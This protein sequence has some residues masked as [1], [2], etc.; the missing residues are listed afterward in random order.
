MT[1]RFGQD[2][3]DPHDPALLEQHAKSKRAALETLR[4]LGTAE[5]IRELTRR[6]R[7][8]DQG[9]L[10]YICMLGVAYSP[11]PDVART[12]VREAL[13]DPNHPITQNFL[14]MMRMLTPE[15]RAASMNREHWR[16]EQRQTLEELIAVL[17]RKTGKALTVSLSTAVNEAWNGAE[18]S[19][20]TMGRLTEQLIAVFDQLS[21]QDQNLLLTYRWDKIS[22]PRLLPLLRRVAQRY[23]DFPQMRAM[24]A[25]TEL[26]VSG[27]ALRHW[28]ELDPQGA[29]PAVIAEITRLRPRY[30]ARLLGILPDKTLPEVDS[31]LVEHL[32]TTTDLDGSV[33]IASLIARYSSEAILP[34]VLTELDS[35]IGKW[36]CA[37]QNPLLAYVLRVNPALARPRI[38][39]AIVTRGQGFTA[40]NHGLFQ[41]ISEIHFDPVLEEIGIRSLDDP[42]PEIAMT[43]ATM[44]GR[45]GS[46]AAEPAL[47]TRYQRWAQ[48]WAGRESELNLPLGQSSR[49]LSNQLGLGQSL[50]MALATGQHWLADEKKL[51]QLSNV[52]NVARVQNQ[53]EEYLKS[54]QKRP[55]MISFSHMGPYDEFDARVCQY[56]LHSMET[57]KEKLAQFPTGAEFVMSSQT[58]AS[59]RELKEVTEVREFISS[60]RMELTIRKDRQ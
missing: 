23:Q 14:Y 41:D 35:R 11:L 52:S 25:Y 33:N 13:A 38:E 46:T 36:A 31:A 3:V 57:F 20:A 56:E 54:W 32:R 40:C 28:Y 58:N 51:E 7:G 60:H 43:A 9:G 22:S 8:E 29:R 55:L 34:Q 27:S 42:D 1:S 59:P 45:F 37:I 17:P 10:D 30:G 2:L 47:L 49:D 12:A 50:M 53:M 39:Q 24:N 44:L 15:D 26:Q 5:S 19:K 4:F 48:Q 16:E 21:A 18:I 6:M